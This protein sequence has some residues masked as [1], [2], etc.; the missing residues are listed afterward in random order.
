MS[1]REHSSFKLFTHKNN[2]NPYERFLFSMSE[3]FSS[4]KL[5]ISNAQIS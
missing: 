3:Y 4:I 5:G 2:S 1:I